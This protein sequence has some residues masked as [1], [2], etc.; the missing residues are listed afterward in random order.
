MKKNLNGNVAEIVNLLNDERTN[1]LNS[2][3]EA[4]YF[5]SVKYG[6]YYIQVANS[7]GCW[8]LRVRDENVQ[9]V[10][11]EDPNI[12]RFWWGKTRSKDI[13][14]RDYG[15]YLGRKWCGSL[16]ER[17]AEEAIRIINEYEDDI[18]WENLMDESQKM[19]DSTKE[20]ENEVE[21]LGA[22]IDSYMSETESLMDEVDENGE[23]GWQKNAISENMNRIYNILTDMFN[24]KTRWLADL[25]RIT[26]CNMTPWDVY[27]DDYFIDL[28]HGIELDI[29]NANITDF[30]E[31]LL[32]TLFERYEDHENQDL[33]SEM[34]DLRDTLYHYLAVA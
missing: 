18:E 29:F 31:D 28:G 2:Y 3:K 33:A 27:S 19:T 8:V 7:D 6:H 32:N 30:F 21:D 15:F 1:S 12:H 24:E 17:A 10:V 22:Q 20:F 11:P 26:G 9:E 13:T 4:R 34:L 25:S 23:T 14:G 5:I 16:V